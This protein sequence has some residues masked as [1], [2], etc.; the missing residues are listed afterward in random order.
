[1]PE[2]INPPIDPTDMVTDENRYDLNDLK[3]EVAI[4]DMMAELEKKYPLDP[5]REFDVKNSFF[6]T[7]EDVKLW[8]YL[9][10]KEGAEGSREFS[11]AERTQWDRL[12]NI[13][14]GTKIAIDNEIDTKYAPELMTPLSPEELQKLHDLHRGDNTGGLQ[15]DENDWRI[16]AEIREKLPSHL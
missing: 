10:A 11:D 13:A 9:G 5:G 2:T 16:R 3:R 7:L 12:N 4:S 6:D 15:P 8:W 14:Q 1:M